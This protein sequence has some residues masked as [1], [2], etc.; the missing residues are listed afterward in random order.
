MPTHAHG[1]SEAEVRVLRGLQ[2]ALELSLVIL[3]LEAVGAYFSRS[4]S[5]TVDAIHN[6]PDLVAF[7]LSWM[8][9][10]GAAE[11]ATPNFTFGA[12]RLETFAALANAGL[13]MGA[14]VV[15]G[16]AALANL[17]TGGTFAGTVDPVWLLAVA[18]PT[19]VLRAI[20][21]SVLRGNPSRVRDLNLSSVLVHMASDIAIT[22]AILI[23]G[24]V[25]LLRPSLGWIDPAAALAI[26][27]VLVYESLP[28]FRGGFDVLAERT[29][30]GLSVDRITRTALEVPGVSEV[31]DVHV[32]A[33]C[34]S[35]ICL[36]AHVTVQVVTLGEATEVIACLRQRMETEFGIVH[37]TFEIEASPSISGSA[38]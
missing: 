10:R 26:A 9:V 16:Y 4:L 27:G 20:N 14:G 18:V 33:V 8:A 7:G 1:E 31:H 25:L 36:T 37:S 3:L 13:V 24:V 35:L 6:V 34:S 19:L 15:F 11:G 28:L 5:L 32:W 12:H 23:A 22:V 2:L 17:L 30:R 38:G 29:P 21:L